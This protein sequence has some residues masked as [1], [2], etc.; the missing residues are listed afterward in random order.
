MPGSRAEED[1]LANLDA[2][3]LEPGTHIQKLPTGISKL[4]GAVPVR[5]RPET[6]EAVKRVA[7]AEQVSVSAW[8]RREVEESLH[9]HE[10]AMFR[11]N[12][13]PI[14]PEVAWAG[15]RDRQRR[16]RAGVA[17]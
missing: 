7:D 15:I 3:A 4:G 2:T 11:S 10:T 8:I 17:I 13:Y 12:V 14:R 6:I 1:R 9:R 16:H 5:F